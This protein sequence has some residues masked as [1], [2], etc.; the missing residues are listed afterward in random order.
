MKKANVCEAVLSLATPIAEANGCEIYDIEFKKEGSDYFLRL[1]IELAD[2]EKTISLDECEA[3][4]RALS[5]VLDKEDPIEQ[6]Y[7]LEVSSPGIDRQLK[8]EE[9]FKRFMGKKVDIGLYKAINGAKVICG[10][11]KEFDGSNISLDLDGNDFEIAL[12]D[13]TYVKLSLDGL[14]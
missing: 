13:T 1:Y 5:E 9:H 4:S 3:V 7:M 10:T 8:T 11:L 2:R 14:F 12:K 6:A